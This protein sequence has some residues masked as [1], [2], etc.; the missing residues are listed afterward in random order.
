VYERI[1][2]AQARAESPP[3]IQPATRDIVQAGAV[4]DASGRNRD[5]A[6]VLALLAFV[7]S[8]ILASIAEKGR[9]SAPATAGSARA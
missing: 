6:F 7:I 5:L 1:P 4:R 8:A 3:T 9:A 2:E